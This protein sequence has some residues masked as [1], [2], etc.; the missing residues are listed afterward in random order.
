MVPSRARANT[1]GDKLTDANASWM[2]QAFFLVPKL[3]SVCWHCRVVMEL[4]AVK[5]VVC[6]DPVEVICNIPQKNA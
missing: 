5:V 1:S 3:Q 4:P 2:H 6:T